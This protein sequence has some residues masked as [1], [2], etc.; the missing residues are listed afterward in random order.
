VIVAVARLRH[1]PKLD[2]CGGA[3]LPRLGCFKYSS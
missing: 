1:H 2:D 3:D